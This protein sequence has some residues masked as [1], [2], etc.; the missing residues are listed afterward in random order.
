MDEFDIYLESTG[1]MNIYNDNTM[2]VFRNLLAHPI[3]LEGD[4][5]VALAEIIHPTK[6][7]NITTTDYMIYTPKTQYDSTPVTMRGDGAGLVVRQEDWSDNAKFDAGEYI[8]IKSILKKLEKG[9]ETKKPLTS[10]LFEEDSVE[11]NF[12]DGYGISVRDPSLLDVLGIQ[13]V[14]DTNRG[15]I[16]IGSN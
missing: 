15:G 6:V 7:N 12:T 4:W 2:S 11:L 3:N 14:P 1:S 8:T 13:G 16:F 9:T 5:R 10:A